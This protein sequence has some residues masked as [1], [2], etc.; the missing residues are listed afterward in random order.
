MGSLSADVSSVAQRAK[1]EARRAK[2]EMPIATRFTR[3]WRE[4]TT[5][6]ERT[7]SRLVKY[8]S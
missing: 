7:H 1:G 6:S 4:S 2:E 5:H 8:A 3:L